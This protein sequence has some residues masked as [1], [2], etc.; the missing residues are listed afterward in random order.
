MSTCYSTGLPLSF[1]PPLLPSQRPPPF[2]PSL[3]FFPSR[4]HYD[5]AFRE[6]SFLHKAIFLPGIVQHQTLSFEGAMNLKGILARAPP[7]TCCWEKTCWVTAVPQ[8]QPPLPWTLVSS[9]ISVGAISSFHGEKPALRRR[10]KQGGTVV[11]HRCSFSQLHDSLIL[12]K[13]GLVLACPPVSQGESKYSG[14]VW[15]RSF[16]FNILA[17]CGKRKTMKT[18]K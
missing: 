11:V 7:P 2:C 18:W 8:R 16:K 9:S 3:L 1:T 4:L 12:K 13:K 5:Q 6:S 10:R 17:C 15:K 14:F